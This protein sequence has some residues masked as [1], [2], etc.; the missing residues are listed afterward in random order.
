MSEEA[1]VVEVEAKVNEE[2]QTKVETPTTEKKV[3]KQFTQEELDKVVRDR[4]A[5]ERETLDKRLAEQTA[6]LIEKEQTLTQEN[7]TLKK[8]L[9]EKD[10][11]LLGYAKNIAADKVDEALVLAELK[12]VKDEITLE[13]AFDKVATEFP[14][15]VKGGSK[16]G[17]EVQNKTPVNN[18]YL[19][20]ALLK[21]FPHL[22]QNKKK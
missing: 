8:T 16:V 3:E 20:E 9:T 10:K 5:R 6:A 12:V 13:E 2:Q 4:I 22:A 17:V 21:R 15:L 7:E 1:K 19:T 11:L 18:P 14:N